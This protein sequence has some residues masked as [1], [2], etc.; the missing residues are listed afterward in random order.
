M[1]QNIDF[2]K[3]FHSALSKAPEHQATEQAWDKLM[4]ALEEPLPENRFPLLGWMLIQIL[5]AGAMFLLTGLLLAPNSYV[6]LHAQSQK[7]S[8]AD[9]SNSNL[10]TEYKSIPDIDQGGLN[11]GYSFPETYKPDPERTN[12]STND[13]QEIA[14]NKDDHKISGT[15]NSHS[16]NK[17]THPIPSIFPKPLSCSLEIPELNP[18]GIPIAKTKVNNNFLEI[19][20][21]LNPESPT[22]NQFGMRYGRHIASGIWLSLG[23]GNTGHNWDRSHFSETEIEDIA[24]NLPGELLDYAQSGRDVNVLLEIEKPILSRTSRW[25]L[26]PFVGIQVNIWRQREQDITYSS[27][28]NVTQIITDRTSREDLGLK[29]DQFYLGGRAS[30][31]V[32]PKWSLTADIRQAFITQNPQ[33]TVTLF[34]GLRYKW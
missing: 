21:Q 3:Q 18:N 9:V 5:G 17:I 27:V 34:M 11:T 32:L 19:N 14:T 2:W 15:I 24:N 7:S 23:I 28:Y 6:S 26:T 31:E 29:L 10:A 20:T 13:P 1:K 12:N 30:F 25:Q 8:S 4:V 33:N 22:T 16:E